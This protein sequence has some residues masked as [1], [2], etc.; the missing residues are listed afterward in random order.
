LSAGR[1]Y[2]AWS[3]FWLAVYY[4]SNFVATLSLFAAIAWPEHRFLTA[5]VV[6]VS[7]D[8]LLCALGDLRLRRPAAWTWFLPLE[9]VHAAYLL[10]VGPASWLKKPSWKEA[11]SSR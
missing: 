7:S 9:F 3:S 11:T 8:L 6:K 10:T 5:Y 4:A 1:W 2:D